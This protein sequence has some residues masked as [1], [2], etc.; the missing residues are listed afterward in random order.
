[1]LPVLRLTCRM[2]MTRRSQL[3]LLGATLMVGAGAPLIGKES[4]SMKE[5]FEASQNEKKGLMVWVKGQGIPGVVVK[6]TADAIEMRSREYSRI[7]VKIDSIDAA[8]LS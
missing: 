3:K 1:M 8:A 4:Q 2:D 5:L 7:V 6:I